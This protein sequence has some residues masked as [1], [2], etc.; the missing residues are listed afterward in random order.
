MNEE[1]IKKSNIIKKINFVEKAF[2]E[3][4]KKHYNEIKVIK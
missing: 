3:K 2:E 1:Q 4:R